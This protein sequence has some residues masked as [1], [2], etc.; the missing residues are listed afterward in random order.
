MAATRQVSIEALRFFGAFGIV[1]FHAQAPG[2]QIG[3]AALPMFIFL[4]LFFALGPGKNRSLA[5]VVATRIQRFIIPWLFWSAAFAFLKS[6]DA[7]RD[8]RPISDEFEIWNLLAGPSIHLWFLP[9]IAVFSVLFHVA[10]PAIRVTPAIVI[11]ILGML[12]SL[13]AFWML[14]TQVLPE[15]YAQWL[16]GL[17]AV[18]L[19][20]SLHKSSF[21]RSFMMSFVWLGICMVPSYYGYDGG[22]LQMSICIAVLIVAYLITLPASPVI[23]WMAKVSFG[24][25][26]VHPIVMALLGK[27]ISFTGRGELLFA[28]LVFL[29][30]LIIT[31]LLRRLPIMRHFV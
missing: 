16:F 24:I 19:A 27:I 8:G 14:S 9:Y 6:L 23:S 7:L 3:Y 4:A 10:Q 25:Y 31:E 1:L 21:P 29:V 15:P 13:A 30:A 26:L 20:L 28:V 2:A 18:A 12:V 11:A 5:T 17:P 22:A